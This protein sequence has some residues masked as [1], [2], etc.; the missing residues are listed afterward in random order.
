MGTLHENVFT[1]MTVDRLIILRMRN[2]WNKI[3]EKIKTH[4]L[5]SV[6]FFQNLC[7]LW[8]TVKKC[9]G[10]REATDDNV[11]LAHFMLNK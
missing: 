3:V 10:A 9:S 2:I 8:D 11:V 7:S 6:T 1:V 4:I 5:Y